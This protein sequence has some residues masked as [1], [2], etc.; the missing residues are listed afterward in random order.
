MYPEHYQN[1]RFEEAPDKTPASAGT[2]LTK[3]P[4]FIEPF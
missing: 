2:P 4:Y 1:I 3:R